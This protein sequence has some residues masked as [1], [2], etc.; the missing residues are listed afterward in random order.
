[1]SRNQSAPPSL[2]KPTTE[3]A[4]VGHELDAALLYL[5]NLNNEV[6]KLQITSR[7]SSATRPSVEASGSR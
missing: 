7:P 6:S 1:M 2:D 3:T 5:I 4:D